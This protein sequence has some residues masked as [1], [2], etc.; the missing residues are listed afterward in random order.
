MIQ[1]DC[2]WSHTEKSTLLNQLQ[3][4]HIL[5]SALFA[6][7]PQTDLLQV[8]LNFIERTHKGKFPVSKVSF[9]KLNKKALIEIPPASPNGPQKQ[10]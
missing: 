4:Q 1:I 5:W 9:P 8:V 6:L 3:H 7:R 10:I 2:E